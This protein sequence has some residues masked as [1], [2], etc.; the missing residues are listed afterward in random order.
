MKYLSLIPLFPFLGFLFN[1]L[2]GVRYLGGKG[3]GDG[4]G[5][6]GHDA[7]HAPS[8]LIGI[9]ACGAVFLSFTVAL[10]AVIQANAAPDHT[11]VQVLWTWLPG[12]MAET[13]IHGT[14]G[15]TPFQVDWAYQV[16]PLS[17]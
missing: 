13:S 10:Y 16:D 2:V 7:H 9:V 4:H 14:P 15:A 5:D 12:G 8:P 6:S 17:S 1:F 11:I 3:H